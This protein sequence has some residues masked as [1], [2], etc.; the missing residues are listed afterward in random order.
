LDRWDLNHL[1]N[2]HWFSLRLC[3]KTLYILRSN[4]ETGN[5]NKL[6]TVSVNIKPVARQESSVER[7]DSASPY[8][9]E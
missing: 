7:T 8:S 4:N 3:T 1:Q 5:T 6:L 2:I 9:V